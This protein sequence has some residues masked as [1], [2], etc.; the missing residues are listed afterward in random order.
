MKGKG[1][2]HITALVVVSIAVAACG[3]AG[4]TATSTGTSAITVTDDLG[5]S[6]SLDHPAARVVVTGSFPLDALAALGVRPVGMLSDLAAPAS[7]RQ[8]YGSDAKRI[9]L[10]SGAGASINLE[11][12][13]AAQPDLILSNTDVAGALG[14]ALKAIA[15][16]VAVDPGSGG[17]QGALHALHIAGVLTGKTA[18]ADRKAAEFTSLV[19]SYKA[20]APKDR[21]PVLVMFSAIPNFRIATSTSGTCAVL[22]VFASCPWVVTPPHDYAAY[23]IDKISSVDPAVVFVRSPGTSVSVDPQLAADPFWQRM[24][25]VKGGHLYPLNNSL[26]AAGGTISLTYI[27]QYCAYVMY[28]SVFPKSEVG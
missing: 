25:A 9:A 12:V 11:Q 8:F 21:R 13:A 6:V 22:D 16:L 10:I 23:A 24:S 3:G 4:T 14:S 7:T 2:L 19:D 1:W 20:K 15:P 26:A 17:Y 5:V 28:P 18:L 27:L